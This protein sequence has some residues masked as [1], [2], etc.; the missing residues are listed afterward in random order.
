METCEGCGKCCHDIHLWG[1]ES[2]VRQFEQVGNQVIS[3]STL[4]SLNQ[5]QSPGLHV[6]INGEGDNPE[7]RMS[8]ISNCEGYN[9][10][11]K[12]CNPNIHGTDLQPDICVDM[13]VGST[14]CHITKDR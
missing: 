11:T 12:L 2:D 8:L 6:F 14:A 7:V 5:A 13:K 9:P 10:V 1:R 4:L 3:H